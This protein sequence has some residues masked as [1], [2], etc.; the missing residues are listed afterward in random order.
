M[1]ILMLLNFDARYSGSLGQLHI[2]GYCTFLD[3]QESRLPTKPLDYDFICEFL[4]NIEIY[5]CC[6]L[7]N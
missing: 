3:L 6:H 5:L 1:L 4:L 7:F 2:K